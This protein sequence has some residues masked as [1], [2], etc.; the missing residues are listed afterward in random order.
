ML[1]AYVDG[2]EP[3]QWKELIK[4]SGF[5]AIANRL[6][7]GEKRKHLHTMAFS[8]VGLLK[9]EPGISTSTGPVISYTNS[10][11]PS[12]EDAR[13]KVFRQGNAQN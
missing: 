7:S 10:E 12:C 3:M 2:I 9:R 6:F 4:D 11:N 8:G 13:L 1:W 5:E